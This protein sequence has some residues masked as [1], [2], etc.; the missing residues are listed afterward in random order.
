MLATAACLCVRNGRR[1]YA[2]FARLSLLSTVKSS[3]R[4]LNPTEQR[5]LSGPWLSRLL[6]P[7]PWA[8]QDRLSA[9]PVCLSAD[10]RSPLPAQADGESQEYE[11]FGTLS[12]DMASKRSFKKSSSHTEDFRHEEWDDKDTE[13]PRRKL[14]RRNTP[15]WYFLQCKKL[16]KQNKVSGPEVAPP[17]DLSPIS[18]D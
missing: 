3:A 11:A 18:I 16:I 9:R 8:V 14:V 15:Y 6:C 12:S 1:V 10:P 4:S 17:M 7:R 5:Y 2:P 13:K